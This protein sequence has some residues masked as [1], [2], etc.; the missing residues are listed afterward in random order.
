[1]SQLSPKNSSGGASHNPSLI[2]KCVVLIGN[3]NALVPVT[4]STT[5]SLIGSERTISCENLNCQSK[6]WNE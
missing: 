4:C 1:M 3:K 6:Y 2:D 5:D